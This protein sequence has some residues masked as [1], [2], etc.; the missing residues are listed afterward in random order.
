MVYICDQIIVWYRY[1]IYYT[2]S[3]NSDHYFRPQTLRATTEHNNNRFN[4]FGNEL[5]AKNNRK[6]AGGLGKELGS[7]LTN[8][9]CF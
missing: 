7:R 1:G 3:T 4:R 6:L 8:L 5:T 2:K 9:K